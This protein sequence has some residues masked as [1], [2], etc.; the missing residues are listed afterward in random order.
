[1]KRSLRRSKLKYLAVGLSLI[2]LVALA[3]DVAVGGQ[4]YSCTNTCEVTE[5]DDGTTTVRDCCGG[6]V[7]TRYPKIDP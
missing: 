3:D 2:S 1:M 6:R 7:S 5:N 4:T